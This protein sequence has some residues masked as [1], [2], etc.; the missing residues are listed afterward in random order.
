MSDPI[1]WG[2]LLSLATTT[3]A[4]LDKRKRNSLLKKLKLLVNK[5]KKIVIFGISGTGKS[6][7]ISNLKRNMII[8]ERT[9]S[10]DRVRFDLDDIPILFVDT[11][12]QNARFFSRQKELESILKNGVEGIINVVS[13]GYEENLDFKPTDVFNGNEKVKESYLKL[14]RKA[15]IDRLKEWLPLIQ[16]NHI[17]WILN[18]VNK[19]DLWYDK[20]DDV[21]DHYI[22]GEFHKEF[23]SIE[24]YTNFITIPYCSIIKPFYHTR[25]SGRFGEV[26]KERI[27]NY[28]LSQLHKLLK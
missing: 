7:F 23:E 27:H 12:G 21:N 15:E 18:L 10:T 13:Y 5:N 11:P 16:P 14:N 2:T 22:N 8:A 4:I 19:V 6:Q 3:D 9:E 1:T 28:F 20:I 26:E 25:T 24:K 17:K